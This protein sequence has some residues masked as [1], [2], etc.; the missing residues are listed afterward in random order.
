MNKLMIATT[1]AF[2]AFSAVAV[3]ADKQVIIGFKKEIKTTEEHKLQK[4]HRS[5]GRVKRSHKLLNAISAQLP[6]EEIAKLKQDPA[7]AYVEPDITVG[8]TEPLITIPLSQEYSDSWGVTKIG[9]TT[10]AAAGLTGAGI[11]VAVLDSG[12]D[13]SHPDLKDN[14]KGGYNFVYDNNDPFDDGYISHGTHIAGIIGARNNGTGVVGVAPEVSLYAVKVLGGM[15]TG[16]LSDILAGM[17]WA[18]TNKMDVINMSIGAPIDSAAFK[19][20]CDRAYEAGIIIVAASGNAHSAVEFPAAYDSVIAV[21]ATDQDDTIATFSNYGES[22]ELTAPG[23]NINST[24]RGGGYGIMK[25]TSQATAHVTGATA[26]LLSKQIADDN[27][28]GRIADEIR[29]LLGTSATDLGA[30]GRDQYFGFG[31]VDLDKALTPP[32]AT[33]LEYSIT[34]GQFA[35][36]KQTLKVP[37]NAGAYTVEISTRQLDLRIAVMDINGTRLIESEHRGKKTINKNR[38]EVGTG[39]SLFTVNIG[40]EGTLIFFPHG[41]PGATASIRITPVQ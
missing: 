32:A 29:T 36:S 3:A 22:V 12:I 24:L 5:G 31:R 33:T 39:T 2:F 35:P 21:S 19:D 18:I 25:G 1:L 30:V 38:S 11:K 34:I 17:E 16:D 20:A 7:I 9:G 10:A 14:Y 41:K 15:V 8:L 26:I 4:L 13:Y 6:E 27:G 23:V 40:A 37:L 28:D